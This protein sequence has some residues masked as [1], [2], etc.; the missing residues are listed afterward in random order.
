MAQD[1]TTYLRDRWLNDLK[2]NTPHVGLL[3]SAGAEF[4]AAS[5]HRKPISFGSP[6]D[7]TPE[8]RQIVQSAEVLFDQAEEDWGTA[9]KLGI[10][11]AAS[12]GDK[13]TSHNFD[14]DAEF[15]IFSGQQFQLPN[16]QAK[17]VVA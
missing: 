8:G 16:G 9:A 7:A 17:V 3:T 12:G 4:T 10:F 11:N 6:I 1:A 14:D 13:M 15:P 5:Y 2:N